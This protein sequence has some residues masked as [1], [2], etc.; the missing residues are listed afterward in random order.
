MGRRQVGQIE[1]AGGNVGSATTALSEI[2]AGDDTETVFAL[3]D[4]G[5]VPH[6]VD[7][8]GQL[9][10]PGTDYTVSGNEVTL[11]VA[12]ATG[13]DVVI[14]YF[15]GVSIS[16]D[17]LARVTVTT[18]GATVVLDFESLKQ[19]KFVG[20]VAI[21]EIA[22]WSIL[23]ATNALEFTAFV[24]FTGAFAQTFPAS[25]ILNDGGAVANVW[26]PGAGKYKIKG[27]FDGTNW[28][29]DIFGPNA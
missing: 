10:R 16:T 5:G 13:Q 4:T 28:H 23:N 22:T 3:A 25:F 20:S 24:E 14:H 8:G 1:S 12:P 18:S 26:T 2:F 9:M 29:V 19:K 7:V 6:L 17:P 15:T 11:A 21:D 27:E